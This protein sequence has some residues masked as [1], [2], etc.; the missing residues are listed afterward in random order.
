MK[1]QRQSFAL[2]LIAQCCACAVQ[3]APSYS[4]PVAGLMPYQR[5]ANAPTLTV[6]PVLDAK[7]ALHGVSSPIPESLKFLNDQGGWFNPFTHPGMT[8][9]YD[10]RGWHAAP[11]L[12]PAAD[13][14]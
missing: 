1:P 13:K 14:K 11:A 10:L 8:G 12:L 2:V 7:Q 9:P 4:Y 6:N 5:P 3:A